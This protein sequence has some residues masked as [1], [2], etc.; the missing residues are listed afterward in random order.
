MHRD[1]QAPEKAGGL[2]DYRS[3]EDDSSDEHLEYEEP[4]QDYESSEQEYEYKNLTSQD[5]PLFRPSDELTP[6]GDAQVFD[7]GSGHKDYGSI[8][9]MH[10]EWLQVYKEYINKTLEPIYKAALF[11]EFYAGQEGLTMEE[12][13]H[14]QHDST[15][16]LT[17]APDYDYSYY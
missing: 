3:P 11:E 17:C 15:K 6:Q 2:W 14:W 16:Y 1:P 12:D 5:Y 13:S 9:W 4:S 8:V 10:E 7:N